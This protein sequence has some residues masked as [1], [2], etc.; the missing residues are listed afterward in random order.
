MERWTANGCEGRNRSIGVEGGG[1]VSYQSLASRSKHPRRQSLN[2]FWHQSVCR[3]LSVSLILLQTV[4]QSA[5]A[6]LLLICPFLWSAFPSFSSLFLAVIL[7]YLICRES[8]CHLYYIQYLQSV[9][10]ES[11]IRV[12]LYVDH[13]LSHRACLCTIYGSSVTS[14][15]VALRV[16]KAVVF[17]QVSFS[18]PSCSSFIALFLWA[19]IDM[20]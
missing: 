18:S 14:S 13:M 16:F 17:H 2:Q 4:C 1:R 10:H 20:H 19:D 15:L 3:C 5:G 7:P 12:R 11:L 8:L 9:P 6:R